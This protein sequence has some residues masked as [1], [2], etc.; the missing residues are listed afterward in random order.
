MHIIRLGS[1]SMPDWFQNINDIK[2]DAIPAGLTGEKRVDFVNTVLSKK[3]K[4]PI[5]LNI[6]TDAN[7]YLG[8]ISKTATLGLW[9]AG[10]EGVKDDA[11]KSDMRAMQ[12]EFARSSKKLVESNSSENLSKYYIKLITDADSIQE[13]SNQAKNDPILRNILKGLKL[14]ESEEEAG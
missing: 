9:T 14:N 5:K 11:R 8:S 4:D 1:Q 7:K 2:S 6:L 3:Q 13:L 12:E 10:K